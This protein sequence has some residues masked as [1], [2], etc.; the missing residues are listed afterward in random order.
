MDA[1]SLGKYFCK[2]GFMAG[3]EPPT[4]LKLSSRTHHMS[5]R[6]VL[7]V[8]SGLLSKTERLCRRMMLTTQTL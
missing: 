7:L 4:I 1:R 2:T 3:I 6:T 8:R 5:A